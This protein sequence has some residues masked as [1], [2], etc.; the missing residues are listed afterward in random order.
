MN[1]AKITLPLLVAL[2]LVC[3]TPLAGEPEPDDF[4]LWKGVVSHIAE[5]ELSLQKLE[6]QNDHLIAVSYLRDDSP[7]ELHQSQIEIWIIQSGEATLV[8]GGVI[9]QPEA[10][11]PY[12]IRGTSISGGSETQLRQ[13]DVVEIR[14]NVPHQLRIPKGKHLIYTTVRMDSR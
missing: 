5:T 7:A 4:T 9:L 11:E 3:A 14:A 6:E 13:G 12:E 2:L 8:I 10:L 1:H